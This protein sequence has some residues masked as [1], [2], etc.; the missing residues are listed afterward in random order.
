ME[1]EGVWAASAA[2]SAPLPPARDTGRQPE[3]LEHPLLLLQATK[4]ELELFT[5]D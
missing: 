3:R 1:Q 4:C 2:P 5:L